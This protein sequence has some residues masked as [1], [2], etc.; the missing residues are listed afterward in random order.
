MKKIYRSWF[1]LMMLAVESQQVIVLRTLKLAA[2][3]KKAKAEARRMVTEKVVSIGEEV[4]KL[5]M[6]ATPQS[7]I[8]RYR[9]KVRANSRR[10]TKIP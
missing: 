3:G 6:G 9:K 1:N 2:G 10:L 7:V 8:S 4:S 5:A